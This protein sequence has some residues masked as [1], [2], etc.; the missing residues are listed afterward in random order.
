MRVGVRDIL[1]LPAQT[2]GQR[3][4]CE[5]MTRQYASVTPQAISVWCRQA[6][7]TTFYATYYG[8]GDPSRRLPEDLDLFFIGCHTHAHPS[9]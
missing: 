1:A 4:Y 9:N 5:V 6:G 3:T 2:R 7:H 8:V